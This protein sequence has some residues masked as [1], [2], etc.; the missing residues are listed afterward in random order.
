MRPQYSYI[1][2][3]ITRAYT[4]KV[5]RVT[6]SM[7]TLNLGH[8]RYPCILVVFDRV[9]AAR[10]QFKKTWLLHCEQ[11]PHIEGRTVTVVRTG[12]V[13]EAPGHYH[14]KLEVRSL[15]PEAA[16]LRRIGGP[17]KEFWVEST[18][19]NYAVTTWDG[20]P[21]RDLVE[22][23]AWRVE[24]SP[25][26]PRKA[27]LFLHTLAVMDADVQVGPNVE[28]LTEPRC[29]GIVVLD[30]AVLFGRDAEP[31]EQVHF[32]IARPGRTRILV[33]DL[34]PGYWRVSLDGKVIA[35]KLPVTQAAGSLYIEG[36]P[37]KY[38]LHRIDA[39]LPPA[40]P[41]T[42]WK[43]LGERSRTHAGP[44]PKE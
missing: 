5:E 1:A 28:M 13:H 22:A 12:R 37:G 17:G 7:V 18:R 43:A 30:R 8:S 44:A 38:V 15:L 11:E 35:V 27:D 4:N 16:T 34:A 9:V 39:T 23:G 14:G 24:V 3:D 42:F 36:G 21:V 32:E 31:Q 2:G 41:E 19:S 6:R 33:C 20:K 40:R 26:E 10:G 25:A 29:V